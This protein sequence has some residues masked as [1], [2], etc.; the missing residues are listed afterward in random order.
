[1]CYVKKSDVK[2]IQVEEGILKFSRWRT[3]V[4]PILKDKS[5]RLCG[6]YKITV[7]HATNTES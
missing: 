5:I 2:S 7:N 4:V 6:D 1:M 3:P